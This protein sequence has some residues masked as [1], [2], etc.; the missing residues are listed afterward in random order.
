MFPEDE[1]TLKIPIEN[2]TKMPITQGE[3]TLF[4]YD[5][6][7]AVTIIDQPMNRQGVYSFPVVVLGQQKVIHRT[8]VKARK[9][10]IVQ[11]R[12][13]EYTISDMMHLGKVRLGYRGHFRRE[14]IVYPS[15]VPV[16]GLQQILQ[17]NQGE[18]PRNHSL[19]ED[20]MM[21]MGTRD[22]TSGDPFNRINWK[23]SARTQSLQ[24]K[25]Y[26]RTTIS[27]WCL[28]VNIQSKEIK[29]QTIE[30]LEQVLSHVA[31]T[32]QFAIENQ[33]SFELFINM[34]GPSGP[35]IHLPTGSGKD[36]L[37]KALEL[38]ARVSKSTILTD[39]KE[40]LYYIQ[41]NTKNQ[42]CYL[43]FGAV[44]QEVKLN[45]KQWELAGATVYRVA[46]NEDSGQVLSIGGEV[47]E[48]QGT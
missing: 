26:E 10:G 2:I 43:H 44:N 22:Y 23:A 18:H 46:S 34:R 5:P 21:A 45:Y 36:H 15:L 25:V 19:H 17:Y 16:R 33:I 39:S 4:L 37:L 32:C 11:L 40:M 7:N 13:I 28:I 9:R 6:D 14:L 35:F 12:T 20:M 42:L 24:T 31:Y 8:N 41:S 1:G 38:L 30:N 27:K 29:R 47:D 48:A 3:L